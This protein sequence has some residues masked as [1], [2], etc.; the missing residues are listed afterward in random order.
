[1]LM[2][3]AGLFFLLAAEPALSGKWILNVEASDDA[4]E[5]MLAAGG[6]QRGP[7]G[8]GG[9]GG[10]GH[11]GGRPGGGMG[12]GGGHGHGGGGGGGHEG[13]RAMLEA[14]HELT[15]TQTANE[16]AVLE[17]EGR[18]RAF[19]PDGKGYKDSSGTEVKTRWRDEGL[20][21]ESKRE[22]GPEITETFA[23]EPEPRR[24]VVTLRF[25]G[26]SGGPIS[27]RRVYDPAAE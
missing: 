13:M 26:R 6:G 11:G 4:R 8:F 1:M 12:T 15:I 7:G 22:R 27:I 16:V 9:G 17:T 3:V 10:M 19:H 20:V 24:L 23:L 5:K 25:E 21:V 2:T 14:A 18:L